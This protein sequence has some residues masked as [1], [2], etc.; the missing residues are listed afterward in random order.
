MCSVCYIKM[1]KSALP[2]PRGSP[3]CTCHSVKTVVFSV[4]SHHIPHPRLIRATPT[5]VA[6]S[7]NESYSLCYALRHRLRRGAKYGTV[8][9]LA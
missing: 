6:N 1:R 9:E 2:T 7:H 3:S 5:Q 8:A 4:P